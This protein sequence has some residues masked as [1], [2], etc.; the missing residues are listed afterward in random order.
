[1][2]KGLANI[3][4]MIEDALRKRRNARSILESSGDDEVIKEAKTDSVQANQRL[5]D[6]DIASDDGIAPA[7]PTGVSVSVWSRDVTV[8]WDVPPAADGVKEVTVRVYNPTTSALVR[9]ASTDDYYL[10]VNQLDANTDYETTVQFRDAW[11]R[12]SAESAAVAFT[13]SESVADQITTATKAFGGDIAGLLNAPEL[14]SISDPGKLAE[15]V[16]QE[17]SLAM[18]GRPNLL[19][20]DVATADPFDLNTEP[21]QAAG[22]HGTFLVADSENKRTISWSVN[23]GIVEQKFYD[24]YR[25]A[26][27]VG[28]NT[29]DDFI[30]SCTVRN[31]TGV[32]VD[33]HINY[34]YVD[35]VEPNANFASPTVTVAAGEEKVLSV[36][37][38]H[39]NT[40]AEHYIRITA[41]TTG[42]TNFTNLYVED[43]M[44]QRANG[45][46][47]PG[48]YKP[49]GI[50]TGVVS[51]RLLT[52]WDLA[53]TRAI[54]GDATIEGAK[55]AD[56]AIGAAQ[57]ANASIGRAEIQNGEIIRAKI[58]TAAIGTAEVDEMSVNRLSTGT[59][60]STNIQLAG[61]GYIQAMQAG[62]V[63]ADFSHDGLRL[64]DDGIFY[65]DP[66]DNPGAKVTPR[67]VTPY[68]AIS[69]QQG[70]AI[71]GMYQVAIGDV[72]RH[73]R[74]A[75][76]AF[77]NFAAFGT[78]N[79]S[80]VEL[81]A[82]GNGNNVLNLSADVLNLDSPK[83][84]SKDTHFFQGDVTL[85]S[86]SRVSFTN[87]GGIQSQGYADTNIGAN[88]AV[89]FTH[90]LGL[91]PWIMVYHFLGD[92]IWR[93][94][95]DAVSNFAIRDKDGGVTVHNQ[96][97]AVRRVRI[98][99]LR[100]I[101]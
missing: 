84:I 8:V 88:S 63:K 99:I 72:D 56:A 64:N 55:I 5:D 37:F 24:R 85:Q 28:G 100:S 77:P 62:N 40:H 33:V 14:A 75:L 15:R 82:Q 45:K 91:N 58:A 46:T 51:A 69:F 70:G 54:I 1:M 26:P 90:T 87:T 50:S 52:A 29:G 41:E 48:N 7:T 61:T 81:D 59:L 73:G 9:E 98:H 30:A 16:V 49:P 93:P 97:S 35:A 2:P 12:F 17:A 53:A 89:N 42:A 34:F 57:I 31:R 71:R 27:L 47:E 23:D 66:R 19:P 79:K 101:G 43:F 36:P 4:G 20:F 78:S 68:S 65:E 95:A 6:S 76:E 83:I 92:G 86:G 74:L 44:V 25:G 80:V 60:S 11:N 38:T 3:D 21:P 10:D 67:R 32:N 13:S 22:P 39:D 94:I 18:S 96:T